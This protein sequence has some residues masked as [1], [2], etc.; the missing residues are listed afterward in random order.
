MASG[1]YVMIYDKNQDLL[2]M[3]PTVKYQSVAC[4]Q[5]VPQK[6]VRKAH[7]LRAHEMAV[8]F[9]IRLVYR[10]LL[11]WKKTKRDTKE[12]IVCLLLMCLWMPL[13]F[14][15]GKQYALEMGTYEYWSRFGTALLQ[16]TM[17]SVVIVYCR[18]VISDIIKDVREMGEEMRDGKTAD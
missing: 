8:L 6:R 9:M 7:K 5:Y 11:S 10:L 12:G 18:R 16:S 3:E 2:F 15:F 4:K 17:V 13:F 14:H 1:R